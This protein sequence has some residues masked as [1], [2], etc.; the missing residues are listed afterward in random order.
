MLTTSLHHITPRAFRCRF[1]DDTWQHEISSAARERRAM[2]SP[3]P[4]P[5]SEKKRTKPGM[6]KRL[7]SSRLLNIADLTLDDPPVTS[8]RKPKKLTRSRTC[9]AIKVNRSN[10]RDGEKTPRRQGSLTESGVPQRQHS[11]PAGHPPHR[12]PENRLSGGA[13]TSKSGEDG[14]DAT[15]RRQAAIVEEEEDDAMRN[16]LHP[17]GGVRKPPKRNSSFARLRKTKT[18]VRSVS[19]AMLRE[20]IEYPCVPELMLEHHKREPL[21]N[22]S[23]EWLLMELNEYECLIDSLHVVQLMAKHS[24]FFEVEPPELVDEFFA[25]VDTMPSYDEVINLDTWQ[26]FRDVKYLC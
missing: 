7:F 11:A 17:D 4:P 22:P 6:L 16:L 8:R 10:S 19:D 13:T 12:K 23:E 2:S 26:E 18:L 5:S 15:R 1:D 3:S 24:K 21:L 25:Y 20:P 9:D 14:K